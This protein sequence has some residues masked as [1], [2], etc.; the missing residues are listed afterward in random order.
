MVKI[1]NSVFKKFNYLNNFD[2]K[3][4][5]DFLE[6]T[7]LTKTNE[8]L[9]KKFKISFESIIYVAEENKKIISYI[10]GKNNIV[11]H[12]FVMDSKHKKGI[13]RQLMN[14]FENEYKNRN[15]SEIKLY[16]SNYARVFIKKLNIKRLLE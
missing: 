15:F 6:S 9:L 16:S 2:E 4:I 5:N 1:K 10:K 12:L 3:A 13:G 7:N 11:G 8:E 14:K